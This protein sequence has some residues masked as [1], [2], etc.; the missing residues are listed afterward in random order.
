[1]TRAK[2]CHSANRQTTNHS[3]LTILPHSPVL[4][5]PLIYN[6]YIWG[7]EY[8]ARGRRA[9]TRTFWLY[10]IVIKKSTKVNLITDQ[11]QLK[12]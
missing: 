3:N 7:W 9:Y 11:G 8:R 6:I 4:P 1:M 2:A 10:N 5:N 12:N